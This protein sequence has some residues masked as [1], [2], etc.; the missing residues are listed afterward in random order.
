MSRVVFG[1]RGG[2]RSPF[3]GTH[4]PSYFGLAFAVQQKNQRPIDWAAVM[5]TALTEHPISRTSTHPWQQRA[6]AAGIESLWQAVQ[7]G[8]QVGGKRVGVPG[9]QFAERSHI[10][11]RG[12]GAGSI[13]EGGVP[14]GLVGTRLVGTAMGQVKENTRFWSLCERMDFWGVHGPTT[15]AYASQSM[16]DAADSHQAGFGS[17]HVCK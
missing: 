1:W 4:E 13:K 8:E 16:A 10:A 12:P 3:E 5:R 2:K 7:Y 9:Q 14:D 11:Q 6:V 15:G 17:V